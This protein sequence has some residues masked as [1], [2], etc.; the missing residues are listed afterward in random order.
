MLDIDE[1]SQMTTTNRN[2]TAVIAIEFGGNLLSR[3]HLLAFGLN[4]GFIL[5]LGKESRLIPQPQIHGMLNR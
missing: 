4:D 5:V 1:H 2:N 3:K